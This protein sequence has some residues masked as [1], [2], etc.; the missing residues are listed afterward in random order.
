MKK[1]NRFRF[2]NTCAIFLVGVA[3]LL[4][5]S[6]GVSAEQVENKTNYAIKNVL[7][8]RNVQA[9]SE[10]SWGAVVQASSAAN[11]QATI[12]AATQPTEI[13]LT[14]DIMLAGSNVEIPTGKI[15]KLTSVASDEYKID[16]NNL[17]RVI[18]NSG[19]LYMEN[20][21]ITNGQRDYRGGGV[22][23]RIAATFVMKSGQIIGN[24]LTGSG[25]SAPDYE[26]GGAG[27]YNEGIFTLAGGLI[28]G[29][30]AT[31]GA[32]VKNYDVD[33]TFTMNGGII[34]NH[35]A[36][37][38]GGGVENN[39]GKFVMNGGEIYGNTAFNGGGGVYNDSV[40]S[41]KSPG[42]KGSFVMNDGKIHHNSTS[43]N[44]GG[45]F[46]SFSFFTL[47][48]GEIYE[49]SSLITGGGVG[50][51]YGATIV[52]EGGKIFNNTA[53]RGAGVE[54]YSKS[55]MN[56]DTSLLMKG[57]E[58]TNN[59]ASYGGGGLW[60]FGTFTMEGGKISGNTADVNGGG[61]HQGA[62]TST[63]LIKK[64]EISNNVAAQNGGGIMLTRFD[65][66]VTSQLAK[67]DVLAQ[68]V[69]AN[70]QAA[71]SQT[72]SPA[73]VP[74]HNAHIFTTSFTTPFTDAYNNYDIAYRDTSLAVKFDGNGGKVLAENSIRKVVI[75]GLLGSTMPVKP[76]RSGYTFSGWNTN[77]N[78]SGTAFDSATVVSADVT[79]YAQW[80]LDTSVT[81]KPSD[82]NK[83]TIM[84]PSI[85]NPLANA[86]GTRTGDS[87]SINGLITMLVIG[88][89]ATIMVVCHRKIYSKTK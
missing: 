1:F 88:A 32:G 21:I 87:T 27:V 66:T 17:S 77:A 37:T 60:N 76:T 31:N 79:V 11:L 78:G 67:I 81:V 23:N 64:G 39:G 84:K 7:I 2:K 83:T 58:I 47:K 26:S 71:T 44:G 85:A 43:E 74:L 28:S 53:Q 29:N 22:W 13:Q 59:H 73:D 14:Q 49:N 16:A 51:L 18:V 89:T 50:G 38:Y 3:L 10:P 80:T 40:N 56:L 63:I 48:G 86:N 52:M 12:N 34:T 46:D 57:G 54:L 68:G 55:S 70:N 45:V 20:I 9:V 15:I 8:N 35:N 19:T 41:S 5:F 72:I 6:S 61:I 25:V 69:F 4:T 36:S 30:S 82:K 24:K 75:N 33:A 42:V 65:S 62:T